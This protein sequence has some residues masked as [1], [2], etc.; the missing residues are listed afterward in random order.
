MSAI[1]LAEKPPIAGGNINQAKD[2]FNV[3]IKKHP[4][5]LMPKALMAQFVLTKQYNPRDWKDIKIAAQE[6]RNQ[7]FDRQRKI[8]LER[9]LPAA[10]PHA[11][12]NAV[13]ERRIEILSAHE[14]DFF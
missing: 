13:A 5:E 4:T 1:E 8:T 3:V 10:D 12:L 14:K 6:Y 7:Q 2:M 11:L 9:D